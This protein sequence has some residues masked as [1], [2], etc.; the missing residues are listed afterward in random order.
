MAGG[1]GTVPEAAAFSRARNCTIR[2]PGPGPPPATSPPHAIGTTATLLP[3]GKVLVAGGA[4]RISVLASAELLR[5][6]G[7]RWCWSWTATGNLVAAREFHT[8]TLLPNGKVLVAGGNGTSAG[9]LASAELYDPASGTWI[10]TGSLGNARAQH[11]ATLLPDGKVLVAAGTGSSASGV[12]RERG[13][14]PAGQRELECHRQPQPRM[15]FFTRRRC[16]QTARR[17]CQTAGCWW[18]GD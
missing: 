1:I 8:A 17:C 2:P 7:Q 6:G 4:G 10:A 16:C 13:T 3:D 14:L 9:Y 18:Q 12:L 11:T 5:S 15:R